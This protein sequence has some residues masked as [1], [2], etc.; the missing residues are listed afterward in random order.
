MTK[1]NL[2]DLIVA[3]TEMKLADLIASIKR[4][5]YITYEDLIVLVRLLLIKR[6]CG[7]KKKPPAVGT[8][9]GR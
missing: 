3:M 4:G 9:D 1:M 2:D 8:A 6:W 5:P 7:S